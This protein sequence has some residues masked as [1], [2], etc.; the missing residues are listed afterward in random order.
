MKLG[1]LITN[2]SY[3]RLIDSVS[4]HLKPLLILDPL[5]LPLLVSICPAGDRPSMFAVLPA[6]ISAA[7]LHHCFCSGGHKVL[8]LSEVSVILCLYVLY[9]ILLCILWP[10]LQISNHTSRAAVLF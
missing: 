1:K 7:W 8:S 5:L 4:S 10:M 2:I 9:A 3:F 6:H